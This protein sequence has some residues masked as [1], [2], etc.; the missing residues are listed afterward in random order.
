MQHPKFAIYS[1][2]IGVSLL[3][4]AFSSAATITEDLSFT[5]T[6]FVDISGTNIP[7]PISKITGYITV[8]YDPAMKYDDDTTDIVVHSLTGITVASPLGF[9][10]QNGLLE[11]G[12][13]QND[14][15]F[16]VRNTNDLV[17]AFDVTNPSHP[18]FP[19]CAV[20]GYTCGIYTGSNKV[21]PAGY[22]QVG[23]NTGWFYGVQ[24]TVVP[25]PPTTSSTPEPGSIALFGSGLLGLGALV[26]RRRR[27]D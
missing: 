1:A 13:T 20:P 19:S 2:V 22:T 8:T 4:P 17:V 3:L 11:F 26:Y 16:V 25:T 21:D 7:P 6:G 10:Y 15:D 9:T 18:F 14:S 12:G 27:L 5:L 23:Y 24:S